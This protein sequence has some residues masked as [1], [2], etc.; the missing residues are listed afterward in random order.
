MNSISTTAHL[1]AMYRA[2]ETERL[3]AVF[4]DPFARRLAGGEGALIAEVLGNQQQGAMELAIRTRAIDEM[5]KDLIAAE[6]VETILNLGAGLDTRPYRM[7]LPASLHWV[8]VDFPAILTYKASLLKHDQPVCS[9][10]RIGLDLVNPNARRVLFD[11][12]NASAKRVLVLTE[13]VLS[14]L[15]EAQVASLAADLQQHSNFRW[16]LFELASPALLQQ[17]Q[18]SSHQRL[19]DQFFA[20]GQPTFLFAPQHGTEFFRPYGWT[21]REFR[22]LWKEAYRLRQRS[23][24]V[25]LNGILMRWFARRFW[26]TITQETGFV[27]LERTLLSN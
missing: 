27:L 5:I 8:E 2:L 18:K 1:V 3:D 26:Q 10:E 19:F 13:G 6:D 11:Q 16:W 4:Q 9:L 7:A 21:V 17:A 24:W 12:I 15:M 14:Y 23:H 20:H 22:S 25:R